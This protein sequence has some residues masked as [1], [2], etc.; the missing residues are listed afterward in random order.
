LIRCV[1]DALKS[2]EGHISESPIFVVCNL[3]IA[4]ISSLD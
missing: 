2:F 1:Q 3:S 4:R